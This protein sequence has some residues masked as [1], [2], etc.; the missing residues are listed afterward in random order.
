LDHEV[1]EL[2]RDQSMES[3]RLAKLSNKAGAHG[4]VTVLETPLDHGR[5]VLLVAELA[6]LVSQGE[7]KGLYSF[8]VPLRHD[9]TDRKVA[10][11]VLDQ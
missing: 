6:Y 5:S 11:R 8:R 9:F 2:V 10:V 1:S 7:E 3:I 4:G